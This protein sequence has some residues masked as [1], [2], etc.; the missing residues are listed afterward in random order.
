MSEYT[1]SSYRSPMAEQFSA[2]E[3][4]RGVIYSARNAVRRVAHNAR[5]RA[6][7]L[8]RDTQQQI[9]RHPLGAVMIAAAAGMVLGGLIVLA[10]SEAVFDRR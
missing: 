2:Q 4:A 5:R 3:D 8:E 10:V 7:Q 6:R 1:E 9:Q